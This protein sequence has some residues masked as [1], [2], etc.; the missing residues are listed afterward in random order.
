MTNTALTLPKDY[1]DL[2]P[3]LDLSTFSLLPEGEYLAEISNIETA[4]F[5]KEPEE[6]ISISFTLLKGE[7]QGRVTNLT[8]KL[9]SPNPKVITVGAKNLLALFQATGSQEIQGSLA[10]LLHKHVNITIKHWEKKDTNLETG[11]VTTKVYSN[12]RGITQATAANGR[13]PAPPAQPS[14]P[15]APFAPAAPAPASAPPAASEGEPDWM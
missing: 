7:H 6:G 8:I 9:K 14:S 2:I 10:S 4:A 5:L 13:L 1:M 12:I 11:E 15:S 3:T